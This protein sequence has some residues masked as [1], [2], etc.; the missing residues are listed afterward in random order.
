MIMTIYE[1]KNYIFQNFDNITLTEV[2][3]DLFFTHKISDKFPF[4]TILTKDN[5]Y[6]N[7]SNLNRKGFFRINIGINKETFNS[8]FEG[9]TTKK[10][11]EAY[12]DLGIDFT[13]EDII[14][15]HPTYGNL[16][17]VCVVNPSRKTFE[18]LK[19]YLKISYNKIT[20]NE[21]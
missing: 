19:E 5:E 14:Q 1:I 4:A 17:W 21:I 9:L 16:Y 20:K 12:L 15:P 2:N 7:F 8:M 6:D 13:K 11:L 18:T 10:G 3:G